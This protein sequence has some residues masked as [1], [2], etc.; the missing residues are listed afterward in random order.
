MY[1]TRA[2]LD[3]IQALIDK[4]MASASL[5]LRSIAH[6]GRRLSADQVTEILQGK[7]QMAVATVTRSGEPRVSPLD[8]LLMHGRFYFCTSAH[9]AKVTQLRHR[10]AISLAYMESDIV[11]ITVHGHAVL[12]EWGSPRFDDLDREFLAVY[13]GT[14]STKDEAVAF[15]E[16]EPQRVYT[17]DR[18]AEIAPDQRI[19]LGPVLPP[20][21]AVEM[22]ER[23][24]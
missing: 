5:Q 24:D 4:S 20:G 19:V 6:E 12:H 2:E 23:Q 1:E 7:R 10:P 14:P 18:R 22:H 11:G 13:G 8:L 15:I 17:Y 3:H 9:A 21:S 16:V